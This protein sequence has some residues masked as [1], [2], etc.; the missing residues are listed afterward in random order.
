MECV[1]N[2]RIDRVRVGRHLGILIGLGGALVVFLLQW[3]S[4]SL[5]GV[6]AIWQDILLRRVAA[7]RTPDPR[8]VL[9]VVTEES[10]QRLEPDFGRWPYSRSVMAL[11]LDE[12][13]RAGAKVVAFDV[14]FPDRNLADEGGDREL[15]EAMIDAP[16]ILSANTRTSVGEEGVEGWKA[17]LWNGRFPEGLAVYGLVPPDALFSTAKGLGTVRFSAADSS[18]T[19]RRYS[20]GDRVGEGR[21][22]PSL[23]LSI[24]AEAIDLPR[25]MI[26]EGNRV[27]VGNLSVPVDEEGS[28]GLIWHGS[29]GPEIRYPMVGF[30]KVIMAAFA[31]QM[32]PPP[33]P[34]EDLDRFAEQFR[35][36]IV[37]VGVTAAGAFEMRG[38]PLSPATAGVEIHANA[39]DGLL[40]DETI[41]DIGSGITVPLLFLVTGSL[42]WLIFRAR[43]IAVA[44]ALA[45]LVV[46]AWLGAEALLLERVLLLQGVGPSLAAV[47]AWTGVTGARFVIERRRSEQ[48]RATF[49]RYVSP[50]ILEH[51]L[52]DPSRVRLGGERREITILFSDIRG[53]TTLSEASE[54]E[55]VVEMLNEYLTRMVRIL[56]DHGG[57]LDKFIGDAVMGFWNAPAPDPDHASHAVDCAIEMVRETAKLRAEWEKEGKPAI[58]IGVGVNTG[59]AVVG[60]IGSEKVAG[61]TVI[62][63]AV[64]LAS[65]LEGKNKDYGCEII[66]SEFTRSRIGDRV[67]VEFLGDVQVKGKTRAVPIYKIEVDS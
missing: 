5:F 66:I 1:W 37:I 16:V 47:L 45:L 49:G 8:I 52:E 54:P 23:G 28:F 50:Q 61:Y 67:K 20:V 55:E 27:R 48:L 3:V 53:F 22:I 33:I 32:D 25:E 9:V 42:G 56:L 44:V 36:R 19:A 51:L 35:D 57:T 18:A 62:G 24:V 38:T 6:E 26:W 13:T 15:A 30:D 34:E 63:D 65:R 11:A 10:A 17:H 40:N 21:V 41:R 7:D 2:G 39:V 64:N 60:N 43:R 12:L 29:P 46:V 14:L 59:D 31:R 4:P 58:R